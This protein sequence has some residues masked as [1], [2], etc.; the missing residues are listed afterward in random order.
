[1]TQ[2]HV[3]ELA[4]CT[5]TPLGHYLKALGVLR[6]VAEQADPDARG[7][8]RDERFWL[9][10]NL[11]PE[12]LLTFFLER[13]SP[14]PLVA[15]WNLGSGLYYDDDAGL[16]PIESA[17][18][19]RLA[20][21]ATA[22]AGARALAKPFA[23]A[24][25]ATKAAED[26]AKKKDLS[27]EQKKET[28]AQVDAC[29]SEQAR[30][31]ERLITDARRTWR[32]RTLQWFDAALTITG[33]GEAEFP[34]LLGTGGN[35]GRLDFTNN[36]YQHIQRLF[37]VNTGAPT[38]GAPRALRNS[39]LAEPVTGL[40]WAAIGQFLPGRAGGANM[41]A[42]YDGDA[43][44]NPWD[45][46][47]LLE[48]ALLVVPG[49]VRRDDASGLPQAA[50]PFAVRSRAAGYAS[51]AAA[52]ESARGEQWFPLWTNPA[53]DAEI[54]ALFREGRARLGRGIASQPVDFARSLARLGV[55]RGIEAFE[56]FGY[57]ERNGQA[58]LATPLGRW[59]VRGAPHQELL[60]DIDR[61]LASLR[62][63]ARDD[64]APAELRSASRACDETVLDVCRA[65]AVAERWQ[66]LITALG[67][68]ERVLVAG[69]RRTAASHLR[70]I[71]PLSPGWVD[72]AD[73]GSAEIRLAL[74]LASQ[75][76]LVDPSAEIP[77]RVHWSPVTANG[78][79]FDVRNDALVL[80]PDQVCSGLDLAK[81]CVSMVTRRVMMAGR[82]ARDA[83]YPE[84]SLPLRAPRSCC[85]SLAD[86]M[87]FL[88]GA[89]NDRQI[90]GLAR[91]L[92][93]LDWASSRRE[94]QFDQERSSRI[95]ADYALIRLAHAP[96]GVLRGT[97]RVVVALDPETSRRLVA[98]DLAGAGAVA[99]RR[100]RASGLRPVVHVLAGDAT[101][102]RRI[103]ASLAFPIAATDLAR[104]ADRVT[105]PFE[106]RETSDS[107][108]PSMEAT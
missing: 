66:R 26:L 13:Y 108:P 5:P 10:T 15:P 86:V 4:G 92:M 74:A 16:A 87:L 68:A 89:T 80:G 84:G 95:D 94:P 43:L 45:F 39:L 24:I 32:G 21:L 41:T 30:L 97:E 70:P 106:A 12:A 37:D 105:K 67:E 2:V 93:A 48:G 28:K 7:W 78:R 18:A 27:T 33:N 79:G 38:I 60:D 81:D 72:A 62:R 83:R 9:A 101:R 61:W 23:S 100:L 59:R 65:G 56:R 19:P 53:T 50:A 75:H 96:D 1:M 46:V 31:K 22:I 20:E 14:S 107:S 91:A 35:D 73:D 102:A 3:H 77:V 49:I 58:N 85:A 8:W 63:A 57:I 54:V 36:Y 51:V 11:D 64:N 104:C 29:Q 44:I 6:I 99:I 34:A 76:A 17:K 98:G 88:D 40:T 90:L 47:L 82:R 71:P 42:G 69:P 103:A 55:S 25:A 52:D